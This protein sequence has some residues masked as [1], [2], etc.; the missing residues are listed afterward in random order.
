MSDRILLCS[1]LDR[2]ILPNGRHPESPQARELLARVAA[3]PEV[4]L[5]YVTGRHEA[6]IH[7]AIREFQIP[8]PDYAIG[9][10]GTTIYEIRD[11]NWTLDKAWSDE[12]GFDWQGRTHRQL[13]EI[14][15]D[16]RA[17]ELQEE[18]Q[19]NCHKVSYYAK[20]KAD[21]DQLLPA[22]RKLLAPHGIR[23][24]LIWSVDEAKHVGLLDVLPESA[25]K[26]HAIR[27]LMRQKGFSDE[28]TVFAGDSGNDL[29]VLA[30]GVQAVL[31]RN[32]SD[33]VR[34][35]A[36]EQARANGSGDCLYLA[37][38]GFLGMNGNYC[39]GVLEGL[40]HFLPMTQ[41]WMTQT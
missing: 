29:P 25:T 34:R 16:V 31:V 36:L 41:R 38:G 15:K 27:F 20:E 23:A 24:S 9:D 17:I 26:L 33:D 3:R 5:V 11:G 28:K 7:D 37:Q 39:A 30:S 13:S 21:L 8:E 32:A 12:I 14:L 1:D 40:A 35:A 6:L 10:V 18:E 2:T 4:T 19:Q 22:V